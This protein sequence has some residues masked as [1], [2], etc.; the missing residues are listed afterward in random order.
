MYIAGR[1]INEPDAM[2]AWVRDPQH[3]RFPTA[4]PDLAVTEKEG[5]DIAAYLYTLK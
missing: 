2:I 5:R 3:F 1:L 4:M